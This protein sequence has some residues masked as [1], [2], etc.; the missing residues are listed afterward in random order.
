MKCI[1]TVPGGTGGHGVPVKDRTGPLES[2]LV[3][4][5]V[6]YKHVRQHVEKC[7]TCDPKAILEVYL[8]RRRSNPKFKGVASRTLVKNAISY[9]KVFK[10]RNLPLPTDLIAEAIGR[11]MEPGTLAQHGSLLGVE[12]VARA[13]LIMRGVLLHSQHMGPSIKRLVDVPWGANLPPMRSR[14]LVNWLI[15]LVDGIYDSGGI[16][17]PKDE[18]EDLAKVAEVMYS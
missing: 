16:L 2:F 1:I 6:F 14:G 10:K 11:G 13:L 12:S 7:Q 15:P 8:D 9:L 5:Q 17:P 18:L 4:N 3:D